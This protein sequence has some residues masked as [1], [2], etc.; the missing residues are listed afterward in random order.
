M[1][2]KIDYRLISYNISNFYESTSFC[3]IYNEKKQNQKL[4]KMINITIL[5]IQN[6]LPYKINE[7]SVSK[8]GV[9]SQKFE[10]CLRHQSKSKIIYEVGLEV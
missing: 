7:I 8:N 3:R 1:T 10:I 9:S 4:Y 2:E 6:N 5:L